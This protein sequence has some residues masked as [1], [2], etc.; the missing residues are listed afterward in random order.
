MAGSVVGRFCMIGLE[1]KEVSLLIIGCRWTV[2][3]VVL[4]ALG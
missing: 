1:T 3:V 2:V 4:V